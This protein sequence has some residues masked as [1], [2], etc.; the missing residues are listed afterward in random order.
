MPRPIKIAVL[1]SGG[2]TTL[3]NLIVRIDAG[4]LDAEIALV[5]SNNPDA[6]GLNFAREASIDSKVISHKEFDGRH[7]FS[8]AIFDA[9]RASGAELIV[10]GGFLRQLSIPDDFENRIINIHPSLIPAFCGKG[11]YGSRVHQGVLD[12][13]CKLTGCTVHFVDDD[14]DH[15]PIIAQA[16]V[17]VES[18]D[19]VKSLAARVFAAE[20]ELLPSVINRIANGDVS[21]AGRIV[22]VR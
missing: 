10:M 19:D 5:V 14:Y 8:E 2:G 7:S 4:S 3:K 17:P 15:G 20:C 22:S 12:Y 18:G 13:G 16:S 6:K 11:N 9:L 1:I 21:V